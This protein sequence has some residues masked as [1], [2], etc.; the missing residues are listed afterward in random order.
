M[1][2]ESKMS[3]RQFDTEVKFADDS[4]T[5]FGIGSPFYD[6]TSRTEFRI[7]KDLVE[8][9]D[10]GAFDKVIADTTVD[11]LSSLNHDIE[12]QLLGR[13]SAGSL[14][15]SKNSAGLVFEV[16]PGETSQARDTI[17]LIQRREVKGASIWFGR[18]DELWTEEDDQTVVTLM[19]IP[20]IEVGPVSRPAFDATTAEV[21]KRDLDDY[22]KRM[23]EKAEHMRRRMATESARCRLRE[24]E[25]WVYQEV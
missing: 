2:V 21:R 14:K 25:A 13:R 8:R 9:V 5:I 24:R 20:L 23:A 15:L 16:T 22:R 19:S 18:A 6:G 10:P 17:E 7:F 11:V 12:R 3:S 1:L 4:R